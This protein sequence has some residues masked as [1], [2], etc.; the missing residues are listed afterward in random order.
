MIADVGISKIHLEETKDRNNGT[1]TTSATRRHGAPEFFVDAESNHP[2]SR[3][4]D[5]WSIGSVM[6]EWLYWLLYGSEGIRRLE[7]Q[8]QFWEKSDGKIKVAYTVR[9][10]IK[11]MREKM[12]IASSDN[13]LKDVLSL[14]EQRLL[15]IETSPEPS[16]QV[17]AKAPELSKRMAEI[18]T[19]AENDKV[20]RFSANIWDETGV[21][22]TLPDRQRQG[23]NRMEDLATSIPPTLPC[24]DRYDTV[25]GLHMHCNILVLMK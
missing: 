1:S 22:L 14:I 3:D 15:I 4:F 21:S 12:N 6:Y 5:T 2:L 9:C 19:K 18:K 8:S 24:P 11:E 13:A 25:R 16:D 7:L 23:N 10:S 17:R 20:Y